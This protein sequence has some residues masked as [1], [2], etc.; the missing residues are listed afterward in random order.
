MPRP[1]KSSVVPTSKGRSVVHYADRRKRSRVNEWRRNLSRVT[2]EGRK[3]G[4]LR[5]RANFQTTPEVKGD[6]GLKEAGGGRGPR[7]VGNL[8]N[9]KALSPA[10]SIRRK[11]GRK[12]SALTR[13]NLLF[14]GLL[15]WS[16]SRA[17]LRSMGV[18]R[19]LPLF[20]LRYGNVSRDVLLRSY[21]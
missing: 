16:R 10:T 21:I 5:S 12:G 15:R 4:R 13:A 9:Q 14:G 18:N 17:P 6:L 20:A 1:P 7:A 11:G 19:K 2:S 3:E 8:Q